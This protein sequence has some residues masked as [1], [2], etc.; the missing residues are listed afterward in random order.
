MQFLE[1]LRGIFTMADS[2][3]A[4]FIV[5]YAFL[6][7]KRTKSHKERRPWDYLFV[8]SIIYLVYTMI[9]II[10]TYN[11]GN[12][13]DINLVALNVFFQFLY[14][15]LIL[16]AFISQTD[17]IFKNEIIIITR[18]PPGDTKKKIETKIEATIEKEENKEASPAPERT[19]KTPE[20]TKKGKV[21]IS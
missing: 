16:L 1:L 10:I 5:I 17:L 11:V 14:T 19:E 9:T 13:G 12:I 7:L 2:F 4:L 20:K 8:G 18:K 3:I 21:Y 6:F 15:G